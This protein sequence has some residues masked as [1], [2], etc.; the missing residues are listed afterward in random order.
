MSY[1][2]FSGDKLINGDRCIVKAVIVRAA[3]DAVINVCDS[4]DNSGAIAI[5]LAVKAGDTVAVSG[6]IVFN[7]AVYVDVVSGTVVGSIII[8]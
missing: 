2:T 3:S 7:D 5:P 8:G 4:T 6:D 1:I